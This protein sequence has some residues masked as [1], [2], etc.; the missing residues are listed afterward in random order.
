MKQ[1]TFCGTTLAALPS[2]AL[3]WQEQRLLIVSDLHLGKSERIARRS[4]QMLPPYETI[5][6]LTRLQND[7]DAHSPEHVICLGDSFDDLA[8]GEALPVQITDWITRLMAGRNWT[9][10]EGNHDPGPLSL[11]GTHRRQ[12]EFDPLVFRHIAENTSPSGEVS[13]HYHPKASLQMRG[14][15]VTRPC[16]LYDDTR[17]ILPAYGTFTGGLRT[18]SKPLLALMQPTARAILTGASAVE[19]PMPRS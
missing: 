14:R 17:L 10:I 11:G 6:T 7:L 2:G 15:A 1:F 9:W 3:L 12:Q 19:I 18:T 5:D 13:G 8:A 16:F 4:G